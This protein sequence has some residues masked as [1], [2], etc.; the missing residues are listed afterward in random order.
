M[1]IA[2]QRASLAGGCFW[3]LDAAFR[4]LRGVHSVRSGFM[5][6]KF[7]DHVSY[8]AV[9]QGNTGHAEVV[10]IE[11][12]P[13]VISYRQL[14]EVFFVIH[15]PTQLNRQGNDVGTQYRSAIFYFDDSQHAAARALL[16]E[17]ASSFPRPI[18]TTLE[19]AGPFFD[20]GEEHQDYFRHNPGQGYCAYVIAPKLIKFRK[21]FVH[22]RQTFP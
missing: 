4:E 16:T 6:G 11:F 12:D 1:E 13:A 14:L 5:G 9:C 7:S 2:I 3:C 8:E 18:V 15:D 17:R 22:L 19:T 21:T 20:A 10:L